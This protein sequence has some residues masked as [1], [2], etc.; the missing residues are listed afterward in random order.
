MAPLCPLL[1]NRQTRTQL[2]CPLGTY[3]YKIIPRSLLGID[4]NTLGD[5]IAAFHM[6]FDRYDLTHF[7]L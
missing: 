3:R 5:T 7:N 1:S 2:E 6:V 4:G